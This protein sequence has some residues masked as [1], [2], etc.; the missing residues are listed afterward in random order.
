MKGGGPGRLS[1]EAVGGRGPGATS[2]VRIPLHC[3][4][5][6]CCLRTVDAQETRPSGGNKCCK[7][8][9]RGGYAGEWFLVGTKRPTETHKILR[10]ETNKFQKD[11]VV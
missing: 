3:R 5:P 11:S 9:L 6:R 1:P 7:R 10:D 2:R 4:T 8:G